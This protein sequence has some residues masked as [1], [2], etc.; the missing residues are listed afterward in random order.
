M[1]SVT[2]QP[3]P[4][5]VIA[6]F[7]DAPEEKKDYQHLGVS[8]LVCTAFIQSRKSFFGGGYIRQEVQEVASG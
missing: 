3:R 8:N 2:S 4:I 7:M 5:R 6:A 1:P